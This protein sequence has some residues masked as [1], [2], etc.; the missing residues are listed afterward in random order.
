MARIT[1]IGGTGYAGAS[2]VREA[3]ARGHE[4]TAYSRSAPAEPVP[5]VRYEQGSM[6]D[7]EVR[8]RAVERADVVVSALSPR[9][10]LTRELLSVDT[11]LGELA[12]A[13]GVRFGVVGGYSSLRPAP[14][15]PRFADGD[16]PPEFAAEGRTMAAVADALLSAPEGLDWFFVSP[17]AQYGAFAPG[18]ATG[19][20]RL[21]GDVA[22]ADADGKSVI[23]GA[24]F[25]SAVVDEIDNPKH[26]RMHFSVAY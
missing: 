3:A 21:G 2:I 7:D 25:A 6:L 11:R 19:A 8:A 16:L 10:E 23:S 1:V 15:A 24:D 17:A 18:E 22:I 12:A 9:G 14:G 26:H 5:G 20:Y 13:A 4:V